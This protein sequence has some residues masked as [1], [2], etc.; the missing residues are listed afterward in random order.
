MKSRTTAQFRRLFA[1]LPAD[2]QR[3]ARAAYRL[4]KENPR[5]PS[6][7]FKHIVQAGP[8]FYS[9]RVGEHHRATG[10]L[11]GDEV[12]WDWIGTR[13]AYTRLIRRQP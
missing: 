13:E 5:H 10:E 12:V 11:M 2:V 6:L 4:F 8:A 9:A 1:D 7:Q 3:Q